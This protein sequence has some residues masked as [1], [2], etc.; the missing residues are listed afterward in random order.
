MKQVQIQCDRCKKTIDGIIGD[1]PSTGLPNRFTGGFY[2]VSS[3]FWGQFARTDENNL[4]DDC[5]H[6]DPKYK[7]IY[8]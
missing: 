7:E 2:D 4:C 5:M 3:G 6:S 1:V 8:G